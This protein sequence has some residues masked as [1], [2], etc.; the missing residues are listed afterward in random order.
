MS[1]NVTYSVNG[2]TVSFED[3]SSIQITRKDYI[4]YVEDI[5]RKVNAD[6]E[7]TKKG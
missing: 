3:L 5:K 2:N 4:D 6:V 1:L 7:L